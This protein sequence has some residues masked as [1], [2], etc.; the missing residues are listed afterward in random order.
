M[1]YLDTVFGGKRG[2]VIGIEPFE[3]KQD[4]SQPEQRAKPIHAAPLGRGDSD[5]LEVLRDWRCEENEIAGNEISKCHQHDG[6]IQYER[7]CKVNAKRDG[8]PPEKD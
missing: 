7:S 3:R 6:R 2:A 4:A 1:G 8:V 5:L